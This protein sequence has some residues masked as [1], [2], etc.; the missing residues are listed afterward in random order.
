VT[1]GSGETIAADQVLIAAGPW[2]SQMIPGW[3]E[4]PPIR[5]I[6]GVVATTNLPGAPRHVLEEAG[7]DKV[8]GPPDRMFSLVTANGQTSVGSTFLPEEPDARALAAEVVERGSR[9]VP[10]LRQATV[11]AVRACARPAAFDG[12]PIIGAVPGL[13]G[14]FVCAGH[15]P[16][17][18]STGPASARLIADVMLG[19]AAELEPFS[20][21]RVPSTG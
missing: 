12:H 10:A 16:W 4:A 11:S 13:D 1:L 18:I 7:I 9:F 2:T 20:P 8:G 14:L 21:R 19:E 17:G 5:P 3:P 15:G 6:W